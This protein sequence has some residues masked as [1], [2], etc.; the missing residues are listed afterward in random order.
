MNEL[1]EMQNKINSLSGE[2]KDMRGANACLIYKRFKLLRDKILE[3]P[4]S[5]EKKEALNLMKS[6]FDSIFTVLLDQTPVPFDEWL[7]RP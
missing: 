4:D 6:V 1:I 7:E 3:M 2:S 5:P